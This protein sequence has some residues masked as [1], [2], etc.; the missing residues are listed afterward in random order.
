MVPFEA[1]D[2]VDLLDT[3]EE[4]LGSADAELL[5]EAGVLVVETELVTSLPS[6]L[7]N[8]STFDLLSISASSC[9]S[10][11]FCCFCFSKSF[12]CLAF[13]SFLC[14]MYSSM[15]SFSNIQPS[16]LGKVEN[17]GIKIEV[18]YPSR[19]N[20]PYVMTGLTKG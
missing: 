7:R 6:V 13:S 17:S 2:G 3:A 5:V 9:K 11:S 14:K 15:A 10:L 20:T 16:G 1:S 4:L 8:F 12:I 18:R 19:R